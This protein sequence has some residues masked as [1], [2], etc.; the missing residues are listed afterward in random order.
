MAIPARQRWVVYFI[1]L[2]LTL[3]AVRWAGGQD[4]TEPGATVAY[5][6]ERLERPAREAPVAAGK[7]EAVP[8]VQLD[9]LERRAGPAPAGDP[10]QARS[11]EPDQRATLRHVPP[12]PPQAPPLPF[13]YLGKLIDEA[14]TTVFLVRNDR[15][16]VVRPGDTLDGTYRVESIEEDR[17]TLTYLPLDTQQ[18]L[19]FGGPPAPASPKPKAR[20]AKPDDEDDDE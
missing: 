3:T 6:A 4:R 17:L 9:L 1:A 14:Q 5:Q 2:A 7:A 13:A 20:A 18:T 16:Y 11:W 12:P 15:N 8:E 19:S 10:F